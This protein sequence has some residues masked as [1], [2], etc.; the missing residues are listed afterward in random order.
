MPIIVII[1]KIQKY[2]KCPALTRTKNIACLA[3]WLEQL[4]VIAPF[5]QNCLLNF[6]LRLIIDF[7]SRAGHFRYFRTF[8]IY[9][10]YQVNLTGS[11]LFK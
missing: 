1:E 10:F 4:Q 8:S 2:Q 11:G 6:L 9:I 7:L 5:I 3:K